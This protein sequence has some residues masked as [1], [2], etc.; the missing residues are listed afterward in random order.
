MA[1]LY[2]TFARYMLQDSLENMPFRQVIV[3]SCVK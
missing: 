1:W 3:D 2:D